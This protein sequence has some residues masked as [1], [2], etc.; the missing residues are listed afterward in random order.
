CLTSSDGRFSSTTPFTDPTLCPS[1]ASNAG[2]ETYYATF[3]S[4]NW[5]VPVLVTVHARNNG[6]EDV[7][8]TGIVHVIA[9]AGTTDTSYAAAEPNIPNR[10]TAQILERIYATVVGDGPGVFVQQ[11]DGSTLVQCTGG[12]PCTAAGPGD[13]YTLRLTSQPTADVQVAVVTD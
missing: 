2:A 8:T 4:T 13:T 7:H 3:D 10:T 12:P 5:F 9:V 11:S 1:S 6:P